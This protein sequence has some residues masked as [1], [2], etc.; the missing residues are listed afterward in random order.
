MSAQATPLS[1]RVSKASKILKVPED[2]ILECLDGLGI[3]DSDVGLQLL[4]A[5]TTTTVDLESALSDTFMDD[6]KPLQRKAAAAILKGQDP[7][8]K[9]PKVKGT[10][11][12][13][14]PHESTQVLETVVQTL[15]DFRPIEQYKDRELLEIFDRDREEAAELVL[16]RRAKG[17]RFIV[18]KAVDGN[19]DLGQEPID[20]EQ[21]LQLLKK[22]R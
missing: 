6:T 10:V 8:G 11:S 21:S 12:E 1:S 20:I 18:L 14:K 2:R 4:D 5:V 13:G 16:D 15:R 17:Q 7:F 3:E 9:G 19:A 22:S